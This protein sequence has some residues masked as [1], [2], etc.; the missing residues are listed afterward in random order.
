MGDLVAILNEGRLIQFDRPARLLAEPKNA[1]VADF[2]GA[3]R[4][5][6]ALALVTAAE[7]AAPLATAGHVPSITSAASLREALS[8]MLAERADR[9][10]VLDGEG[11]PI[12]ILTLETIRDRAAPPP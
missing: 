11:R 12:G 5:L 6:K 3:D 8:V 10:A 2:V 9:V 1:F 7:A 4:A